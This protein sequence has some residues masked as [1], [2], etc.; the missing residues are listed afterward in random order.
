MIAIGFAEEMFDLNSHTNA[1][2]KNLMF[3]V[4]QNYILLM[5]RLLLRINK[6]QRKGI[7][8]QRI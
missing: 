3:Y 7:F 4:H 6:E 2:L 8:V 1:V 5:K